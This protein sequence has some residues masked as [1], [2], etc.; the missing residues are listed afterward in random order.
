MEMDK[1]ATFVN[2]YQETTELKYI[3]I[4]WIRYLLW[5][6][7]GFLAKITGLLQSQRVRSVD[8]SHEKMHRRASSQEFRRTF[9]TYV[10]FPGIQNTAV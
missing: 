8:H 4:Y 7:Y 2:H 10:Y 3:Y 5:L 9:V 6:C 1:E